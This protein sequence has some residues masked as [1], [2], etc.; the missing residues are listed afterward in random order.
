MK[1]L[2]SFPLWS[3]WSII[4]IPISCLACSKR[5]KGKRRPWKLHK[6]ANLSHLLIQV[7]A[8]V[9]L[10]RVWFKL[11]HTQSAILLFY[12]RWFV[13]LRKNAVIADKPRKS[14]GHS[15]WISHM[16]GIFPL[17]IV[18]LTAQCSHI[19]IFSVRIPP[20]FL[21]SS[22]DTWSGTFIGQVISDHDHFYITFYYLM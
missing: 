17:L 18:C 11:T 1:P 20:I 16:R 21:R 10:N 13:F 8:E 19:S 2:R 7:T 12:S 9:S 14:K 22:T 4:N 3:L 15:V 6:N 5:V